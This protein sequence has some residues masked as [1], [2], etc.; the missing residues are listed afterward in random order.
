VPLYAI[1]YH[2]AYHVI[3]SNCLSFDLYDCVI[4]TT[5]LEIILKVKKLGLESDHFNL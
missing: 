4:N 3:G 5:K 1:F 2:T